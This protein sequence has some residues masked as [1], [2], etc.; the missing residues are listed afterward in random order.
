MVFIMYTNKTDRHP[1]EQWAYILDGSVNQRYPGTFGSHDQIEIDENN[2]PR[3]NTRLSQIRIGDVD[4][5]QNFYP[6]NTRLSQIIQR[7]IDYLQ[8]SERSQVTA[9][10]RTDIVD[11]TQ[12]MIERRKVNRMTSAILFGVL[13]VVSAVI[14]LPIFAHLISMSVAKK[15]ACL[16]VLPTLYLLKRT[17][18]G[19]CEI[20][21]LRN[22]LIAAENPNDRMLMNKVRELF[23]AALPK[24][25][26]DRGRYIIDDFI[27]YEKN[28]GFQRKIQNKMTKL[29]PP[30]ADLNDQGFNKFKQNCYSGKMRFHISHGADQSA[31]STS[32]PQVLL[33]PVGQIWALEDTRFESV[34]RAICAQKMTVDL[35][36]HIKSS[37]NIAAGD[38]AIRARTKSSSIQINFRRDTE[39]KIQ[40]MWCHICT[41]IDI[42]E[43]TKDQVRIPVVER[44]LTAS[45]SFSVNFDDTDSLVIGNVETRYKT[46]FERDWTLF[47]RPRTTS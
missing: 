27:Y 30:T 43:Q 6:R 18:Q 31:T 34:V 45:T 38:D 8:D 36:K 4:L 5:A 19:H 17:F 10:I 7:S 14:A 23:Y 11:L 47:P 2:Y 35:T 13:L 9:K 33:D 40:K 24:S 29:H 28:N 32:E 37:F 25:F 41:I 3:L 15:I 42:V 26:Y 44:A 21:S 46:P 20:Q 1:I 12:M 16:Y 39:H 22:R